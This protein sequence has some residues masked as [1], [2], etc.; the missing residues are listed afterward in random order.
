MRLSSFFVPAI[1]VA[2]LAASARVS[3]AQVDSAG[4]TAV[5]PGDHLRI[6]LLGDDKTLSGEFEVGPDSALKHPLYNRIKVVGVPLPQLKEKLASFLRSFQREPRF[7]VEPLFKVS[8]GGEVRSPNILFLSPETTIADAVSLAGGS[9]D[10][11]DPNR[12]TLLRAGR[13]QLL[14]LKGSGSSGAMLIRSGDQISVAASRNIT[15][16]VI[17]ILGAVVSI[18]SVLILA[19]R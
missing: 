6:T 19:H 16:T 7:E 8:V 2:F 10:R 18:V 15:G 14:T 3:S 11:A 12:V 17:A 5:R 1:L 9:T 4:A 13:E